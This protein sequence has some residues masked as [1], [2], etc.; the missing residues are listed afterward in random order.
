MLVDTPTIH[1]FSGRP[2]VNVLKELGQGWEPGKIF[3]TRIM[4]HLLEIL[5]V[6]CLRN[7]LVG[8]IVMRNLCCIAS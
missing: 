3:H 4:K 6:L 7:R 5:T 8:E 1:E 2:F